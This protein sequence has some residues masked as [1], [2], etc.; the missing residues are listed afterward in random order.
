MSLWTLTYMLQYRGDDLSVAAV[1]LGPPC[2][3][4]LHITVCSECIVWEHLA[5][6]MTSM[7]TVPSWLTQ[8]PTPLRAL[9]VISPITPCLYLVVCGAVRVDREHAGWP[10]V[11]T[12]RSQ[13]WELWSLPGH[14]PYTVLPQGASQPP[15]NT[16]T[17]HHPVTYERQLDPWITEVDPICELLSRFHANERKGKS[18]VIFYAGWAECGGGGLRHNSAAWSAENTA[19]LTVLPQLSPTTRTPHWGWPVLRPSLI[20][21]DSLPGRPTAPLG[22]WPP[23]AYTV[24]ALGQSAR[25]VPATPV[26][27]G[28]GGPVPPCPSWLSTAPDS[29]R[30]TWLRWT[31][32]LSAS[33][34]WSSLSRR[35]WQTSLPSTGPASCCSLSTKYGWATTPRLTCRYVPG[36]WPLGIPGH[37]P[38]RLAMSSHRALAAYT[39]V[40][41]T[42]LHS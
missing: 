22:R 39:L 26:L 4:T 14:T 16:H 31:P 15:I 27:A 8:P 36:W 2:T 38:P 34:P 25:T 9:C 40:P 17:L 19:L 33:Q 35:P 18:Q 13:V 29:T 42:C 11:C 21:T 10:M 32:C 30:Y 1:T 23:P 37:A 5:A 12:A 24:C 20:T 41:H 28:S 3:V 6:Y 7:E